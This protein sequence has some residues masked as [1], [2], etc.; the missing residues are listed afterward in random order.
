M[1]LSP[2][3]SVIPSALSPA[4][5][6]EAAPLKSIAVTFAPDSF[7]T[8]STIA[9]LSSTFISAP[10]LRSS[11][12]CLYLF[13]KIFSTKTLVPSAT[14]VMDITGAWASDRNPGY[15][16]VRIILLQYG[17]VGESIFKISLS[18][19]IITQPASSKF[20]IT[21][22]ICSSITFSIVILLEV[23]AAADIYVIATI[24]S[25]ITVCSAPWSL[26]TPVITI[27]PS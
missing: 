1:C 3:I 18:L 15:G 26:V 9:T 27:V 8:P 20:G 6:N 10:S 21:E 16:M 17:L 7:F 23:A 13:E 25:D 5:T 24:L 19:N 11:P 4:T 2:E 22:L 14:A 12:T